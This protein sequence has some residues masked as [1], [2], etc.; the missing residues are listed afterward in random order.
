MHKIGRFFDDALGLSALSASDLTVVQVGLR[1][2]VVYFALGLFARMGKK[3]FLGQAT[4]FD[5]SH[6]P[7]RFGSESRRIRNSSL[8]CVARSHTELYRR[9][10]DRFLFYAELGCA[11]LFGKGHDAV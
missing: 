11:E 7:D 6:H 1:A 8:R 5:A 3:R 2:V 9:P 4:A 10:L